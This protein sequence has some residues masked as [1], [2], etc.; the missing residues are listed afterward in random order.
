MREIRVDCDGDPL[1]LLVDPAGPA[2]HTG[3]TSCFFRPL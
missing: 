3:A 2:C 1:L